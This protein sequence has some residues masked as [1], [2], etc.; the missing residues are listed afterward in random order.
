MNDD[1]NDDNI[2]KNKKKTHV[3][4][5]QVMIDKLWQAIVAD[6]TTTKGKR[7]TTSA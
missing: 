1:K 7:Q 5:N 2:T 4:E 6:A 3:K